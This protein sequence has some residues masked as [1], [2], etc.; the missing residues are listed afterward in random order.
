MEKNTTKI[1]RRLFNNIIST[2]FLFFGISTTNATETN[3]ECEDDYMEVLIIPE[4][5][6]KPYPPKTLE[7]LANHRRAGKTRQE[8]KNWILSHSKVIRIPIQ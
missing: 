1:T 2:I 5:F 6:R 4:E 8:I 3:E 7:V